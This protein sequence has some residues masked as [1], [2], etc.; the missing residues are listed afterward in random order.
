[1]TSYIMRVRW[2]ELGGHTH[3]QIFTGREGGTLGKAGDLTFTNE[4]FRAWK[5]GKMVTD[6]IDGSI[7][8]EFREEK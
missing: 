4:E 6:R 7:V 5:D 3:M 8:V 1:M 2:K